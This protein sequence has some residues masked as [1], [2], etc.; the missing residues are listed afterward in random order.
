MLLN[1]TSTVITR[2]QMLVNKIPRVVGVFQRLV[3]EILSLVTCLQML[4]NGIPRIIPVFKMLVSKL[5]TVSI[6]FLMLLY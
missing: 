1:I 2:L 5:G 6:W 3:N 4:I